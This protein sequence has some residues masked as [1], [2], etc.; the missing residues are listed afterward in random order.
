MAA[1]VYDYVEDFEVSGGGWTTFVSA[2]DTTWQWGT[3]TNVGPATAHSGTKCWG[4]NI[5]GRYGNNACYQMELNL[6]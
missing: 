4:T 6:A 5:S 1:G 2:P 3:P